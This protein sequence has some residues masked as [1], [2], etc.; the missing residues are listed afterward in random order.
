MDEN[1]KLLNEEAQGTPPTP[2]QTATPTA[3]QTATPAATIAPSAPLTQTSS[4][5][6]T[7]KTYGMNADERIN[8]INNMYDSYAE[9]QK[10]QLQGSLDKTIRGYDEQLAQLPGQYQKQADA[11]ELQ[12]ERNKRNLN[13][14][15]AYNGMNAGAGSQAALSQNSAYLKGNAELGKSRAE[16]ENQIN[17]KKAGARADTENAIN[18]AIAQ[19]DYQRAA[20][21]LDAYKEQFTEKISR[22][23]TLAAYGD[24]SGYED[25]YGTDAAKQMFD[26]WKASNPDLA[27]RMG[28]LTAAEYKKY[29]GKYPAGY[30]APGSGGGYGGYGGNGSSGGSKKNGGPNTGDMTEEEY[31]ALQNAVANGTMTAAD[32]NAAI[33]AAGGDFIST[34]MEGI[35]NGSTYTTKVTLPDGKQVTGGSAGGSAGR[36]PREGSASAPLPATYGIDTSKITPPAINPMASWNNLY[37]Y[38]R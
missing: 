1:N 27:Y 20:A 7:Q 19:N 12:Y 2:A 4:T 15:I 30:K 8:Q 6:T 37:I 35:N 17:M 10:A 25:L 18:Q 11:L 9:S 31:L 26:G 24:F 32:A 36:G 13:E 29:T 23:E 5:T 14:Q 3:T 38:G 21:L 33:N 34:S 16:A 22:A 28:Y